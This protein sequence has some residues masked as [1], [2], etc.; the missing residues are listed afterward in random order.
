MLCQSLI[1]SVRSFLSHLHSSLVIRRWLFVVVKRHT[2]VWLVRHPQTDWNRQRR[3]QSRSDRPLTSF[4][5]QIGESIARRLRTMPFET[6][7]S[8]G[9]MR[10]DSVAQMV[11]ARRGLV[12]LVDR[13]WRD[14][15]Q[16]A[17]E[18]LT[19]AEV[20]SRYSDQAHERWTDPWRSRA[21]GGES[22][23]DLWERVQTAWQAVLAAHDG[24]HLLIVTHATPIQLLLCSLLGVPF[25]RHWQ[26]RTDL[27]GITGLDLYPSGA[28]MRVVN[29]ILRLEQKHHK[30][31]QHIDE[32]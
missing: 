25:E 30:L 19:Y 27:G 6:V 3:Y 31:A 22:M 16:G 24:A 11:A 23:A 21:H 28:I 12:T 9:L 20:M 15:D 32:P 7:V 14:V 17:W 5:M 2:A 29:E 4:G 1:V 13:R 26:F 8:S 10:T 18:G